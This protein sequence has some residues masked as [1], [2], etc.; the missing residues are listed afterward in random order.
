MSMPHLSI[1]YL[2]EAYFGRI[3]PHTSDLSDID[4]VKFLV[5][6]GLVDMKRFDDGFTLELT[7]KGSHHVKSL[8]GLPIPVQVWVTPSV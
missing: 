2:I 5:N 4:A 6:E 7:E 3:H 1:V 8:C